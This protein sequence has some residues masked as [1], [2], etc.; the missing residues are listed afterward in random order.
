MKPLL[1][2]TALLGCLGLLLPGCVTTRTQASAKL[3]DANERA[4]ANCTY[5]GDVSGS[6]GVSVL[7][8][9]TDTSVENARNDAAEKAAAMATPRSMT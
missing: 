5:L 1:A 9:A 4:V 3:K 8:M 2:P 6:S 7:G